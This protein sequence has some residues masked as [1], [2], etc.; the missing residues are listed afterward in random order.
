LAQVSN[1]GSIEDVFESPTLFDKK[2]PGFSDRQHDYF[3]RG[4]DDWNWYFFD[5]FASTFLVQFLSVTVS[6]FRFF[7]RECISFL[8]FN[9]FS[10]KLK[11]G[12]NGQPPKNGLIK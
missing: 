3:G 1:D 12:R 6:H 7:F 5:V 2:P 11:V 4:S 10:Y 9:T 8:T